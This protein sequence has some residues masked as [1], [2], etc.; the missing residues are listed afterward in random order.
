MNFASFTFVRLVRS[1][2]IKTPPRGFQIRI[3]KTV[4][5]NYKDACL[6]CQLNFKMP[7]D[8][9]LFQ[10]LLDKEFSLYKVRKLLNIHCLWTAIDSILALSTS[11]FLLPHKSSPCGQSFK[12]LDLS[13][14]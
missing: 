2:H 6:S 12:H 14:G 10:C 1:F 9:I 7:A 8:P 4:F 3:F 5:V 13:C 11:I